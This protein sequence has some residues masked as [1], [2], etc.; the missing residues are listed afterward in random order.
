MVKDYAWVSKHI[1]QYK[2]TII[3]EGERNFL[4][5]G[6]TTVNTAGMT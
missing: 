4:I 6:F 1:H 3:R 2:H 5:L